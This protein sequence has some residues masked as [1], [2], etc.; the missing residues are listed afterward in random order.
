MFGTKC[1]ICQQFLLT[2]LKL[3][4]FFRHNVNSSAL[5]LENQSNLDSRSFP[6]ACFS[7]ETLPMFK[8]QPPDLHWW[9][10]CGCDLRFAPSRWFVQLVAA[11]SRSRSEDPGWVGTDTRWAVGK[12]PCPGRAACKDRRAKKANWLKGVSDTT[13]NSCRNKDVPV[14]LRTWRPCQ[15]GAEFHCLWS[16]CST[17]CPDWDLEAG[18]KERTWGPLQNTVILAPHWHTAPQSFSTWD[19]FWDRSFDKTDERTT[20][21]KNEGN[22]F[23]FSTMCQQNSSYA[24]KVIL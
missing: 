24:S 23:H 9:L 3:P 1:K 15:S 19:L 21:A 16:R 8:L 22:T 6:S 12:K 20:T 4:Q 17:C 5:S 13:T 14:E 11:A 18:K 2:I 10:R 7:V